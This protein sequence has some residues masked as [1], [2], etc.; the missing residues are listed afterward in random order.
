MTSCIT[1]ENHS[2]KVINK[3]ASQTCPHCFVVMF[4]ELYTVQAYILYIMAI[5]RTKCY[6]LT[7]YFDPPI[8]AQRVIMSMWLILNPWQTLDIFR[9][10][11]TAS[12][13]KKETWNLA[14]SQFIVFPAYNPVNIRWGIIHWP[15]QMK[16]K[17]KLISLCSPACH[18]QMQTYT[19][20]DTNKYLSSRKLKSWR[21]KKLQV[22]QALLK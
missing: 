18:I 16:N 14:I 9:N 11:I 5:W 22:K 13:R 10:A 1:V 7:V 4:W 20:A 3:F 12:Q 21:E 2:W 17:G 19:L 8:F 6:T 15:K